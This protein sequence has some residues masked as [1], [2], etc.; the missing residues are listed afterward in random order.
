MVAKGKK[1]IKPTGKGKAYSGK[2]KSHKNNHNTKNNTQKLPKG[3]KFDSKK[4]N[5]SSSDESEKEEITVD[6]EFFNMSEIDFHT[7]KQ[8]LSV[9]FG[10][11]GHP[12]NLSDLSAFITE[13]LADHV[14]TTVK[15]EGEQSDPLAFCTCIPFHFDANRSKMLAE[16]LASK[17]EDNEEMKDVI[18]GKR[19]PCALVLNERFMNLPAG[20]AG[21]MLENLMNDWERGVGEEASLRAEHVLFL[22]PTFTLVKSQLDEELGMADEQKSMQEGNDGEQFYYQE[23]EFLEQFATTSVHFKVSTSHTTTDSRRAF[24]ESGIDAGR[25]LYLMTAARFA[26]FVQTVNEKLID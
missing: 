16:F 21:P 12:L 3:S 13:D 2:N 20:V 14:G 17:C 11:T 9:S 18:S 7:V 22:T 6:F 19:G 1:V 8:F 15:S 26:E 10:T 24:T 4:M 5:E 25:R 23:A